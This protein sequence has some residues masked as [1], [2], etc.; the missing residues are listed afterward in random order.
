MANPTLYRNLGYVGAS[1][2][3]VKATTVAPTKFFVLKNGLFIPDQK[4]TA[5]PTGNQRDVSAAYKE[6]F[7]YA[8]SVETYMY[9]DE[10]AF[11]LAAAM[12]ASSDTKTGAGDPWT[13][14]LALAD[15]MS[16]FTQ[17]VA[18]YDN[19]LMIDRVG[20]CKI[21]YLQIEAEANKAA[22]VTADWIGSYVEGQ[23]SL[24][25]VSFSNALSD[26][27]M[28][29]SPHAVFTLTG[30]SDASTISGQVQKMTT[31]I[32]Q[33]LDS[34]PG[35]GTLSPI[36]LLEQNREITHEL[37][38]F[39]SG[40][41]IWNLTHYGSSAGAAV[42]DVM[43][44]GGFDVTFTSQAAAPGPERSIRLTSANLFWMGAK[45]EFSPDGKTGKIT[46]KTQAYRSGGTM[47][48][49]AVIKNGITAAY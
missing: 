11:L 34:V 24:A 45:P 29:M 2:Q 21:N 8:G 35:P 19:S 1:K 41:A 15:N 26:G 42:S 33:N 44:T 32:M 43:G 30:P 46:L 28:K 38:V 40:E 17:E 18:Y 47:P 37:V 48:F 49:T 39:F 31:K 9:A 36:G 25:T 12:G 3:T 10:T 5:F 23:G 7:R 16:Y 20:D 4:I 27:P 22:I 13:H 6:S 14:T